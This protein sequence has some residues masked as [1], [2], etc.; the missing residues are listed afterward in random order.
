MSN[1]ITFEENYMEV[2][3]APN[4]LANVEILNQFQRVRN[5]IFYKVY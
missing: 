2:C 5:N 1:G 3:D 4:T